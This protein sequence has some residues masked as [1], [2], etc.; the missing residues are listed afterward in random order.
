MNAPRRVSR[1]VNKWA[2]RCD[3]DRS[4][5][6]LSGLSWV[7][8]GY[9][10]PY[11]VCAEQLERLDPASMV[12]GWRAGIP[13]P[14]EAPGH[15][16]LVLQQALAAAQDAASGG[17][18]RPG[19]RVVTGWPGELRVCAH[20]Y[21]KLADPYSLHNKS[22]WRLRRSECCCI[23]VSYTCIIAKKSQGLLHSVGWTPLAHSV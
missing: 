12:K 14:L 17:G 13:P 20:P 23:A 22:I 2:M 21:H 18:A 10:H 15:M 4:G 16:Q 19:G 7:A 11:Q 5:V 9:V 1:L 3:R 6:S 8:C